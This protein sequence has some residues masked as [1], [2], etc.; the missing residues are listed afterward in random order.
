VRELSDFE[1][2]RA[3][4]TSQQ[5][6]TL[7]ELQQAAARIQWFHSMDLGQGVT[8]TGYDDT[9]KRLARMALPSSFEGKRVLDVGAW[10]GFFSFEAERRGAAD[11]LAIDSFAWN[12]PGWSGRQGFDLAHRALRSRVRSLEIDVLEI[13]PAALGGTFDVVFL[14]GVL[15]H[16]KHPLLALERVASVTE[17]L[18]V[19]E[20]EVDNL[21]VPW[22]SLAFY[23]TAELNRDPTNWFS[24]NA[25]AVAG[26]LHA[27]GF[28]RVAPIAPASFP[29]RVARALKMKAREGQP[30]LRGLGRDRITWHARKAA[31]DPVS[32]R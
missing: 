7:N 8:T 13:S 14:L 25:R 15:Y 22:P 19:L 11:V 12:A 31:G 24:P 29:R 27:V 30:F 2:A 18:L 20:T 21:L 1:Q 32:T 5:P 16:M 28:D 10:D 9:R 26:M 4:R 23:P 17:E 3:L 6:M